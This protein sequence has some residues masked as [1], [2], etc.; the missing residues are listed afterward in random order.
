MKVAVTGSHGYIGWVLRKTLTER[1]IDV[2]ACDNKEYLGGDFRHLKSVLHCSYDDHAFI[3]TVIT[4]QIDTIFH[5]GASS[6]LGPSATNPLL[7]YWNNTARTINMI[8]QL[9]DLGWQGHIIFSSTAAVYGAQDDPVTESSALTPCNNYGHSKLMCEN[10]LDIAPKYGIDVTVFRYF[11]VAG[12]YEDI[13]QDTGEPH[14]ITRICN[15]AAG[16]APLSVFGNDYPTDDG[17]CVRDYVHVRDVCE[18]Q[19]HAMNLQRGGR[20]RGVNKYNLGTNTGTS[21]YEIISAF[22]DV[23]RIDVPYSIGRRRAGD[24]AFLVA[25]PDK[26]VDTGFEYQYSSIEQIVESAWYYYKGKSNGI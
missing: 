5:L 2:Y 26:F 20:I 4:N 18:A 12:A 25:N 7:Y 6:L 8:K 17:T 1:G 11:N 10:V 23:N 21:V 19:I 14:I 3:Q 22:I 9:T 24:P 15:A 13:G 16:D